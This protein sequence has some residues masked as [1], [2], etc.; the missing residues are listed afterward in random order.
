MKNILNAVM[1]ELG[2]VPTPEVTKP[3]SMPSTKQTKLT[4]LVVNEQV[5][6]TLTMARDFYAKRGDRIVSVDLQNYLDAFEDALL[7]S[8]TDGDSIE[9]AKLFGQ[10]PS[11]K[12]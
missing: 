3:V 1:K 10:V 6:S 11:A 7:M 8:S 5:R 4:A 2:Y 9:T 12:A